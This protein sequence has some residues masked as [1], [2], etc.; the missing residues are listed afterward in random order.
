MP[1]D[2]AID[3]FLF[4]TLLSARSELGPTIPIRSFPPP[5]QHRRGNVILTT[6][7]DAD[8]LQDWRFIKGYQLDVAICH[9]KI[10]N[11]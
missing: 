7:V 10:E 1:D 6:R 2:H 9:G 3:D 5:L 11:A 4:D 8:P